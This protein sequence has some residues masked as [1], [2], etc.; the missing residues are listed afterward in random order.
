MKVLPEA[1]VGEEGQGGP[2]GPRFQRLCPLPA[3]VSPGTAWVAHWIQLDQQTL[4]AAQLRS[5]QARS[6]EYYEVLITA[7]P[8]S[9]SMMVSTG[10]WWPGQQQ[11]PPSPLAFNITPF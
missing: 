6:E 1:A 8:S 7:P 9:I 4:T 5:V 3:S 11:P 2:R 10:C